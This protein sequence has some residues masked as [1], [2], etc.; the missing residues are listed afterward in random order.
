MFV[1]DLSNYPKDSKF[2][3]PVN[4]KFIGKMNMSEGKLND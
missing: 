4:E 2:Y 3:D 1:F